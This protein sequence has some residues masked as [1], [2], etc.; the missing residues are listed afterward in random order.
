M[1][2]IN[3]VILITCAALGYIAIL[4]HLTVS[5]LERRH[6]R[7]WVVAQIEKA[8][9]CEASIDGPLRL[10]L[11]VG[12][13]ISLTGLH[14]QFLQPH[15]HMRSVALGHLG[16]NLALW[17]LL[18]DRRVAIDHLGVHDLILNLQT[19]AADTPAR[20]RPS[21]AELALPVI[22]RLDIRNVQVLADA[23]ARGFDTLIL[24]HL[25]VKDPNDQDLE[26]AGRGKIDVYPFRL[27]GRMG[28]VARL[29][30]S[31]EPYNFD[32]QLRLSDIDIRVGGLIENPLK[33]VGLDIVIKAQCDDL[34]EVMRPFNPEFPD[35]GRLKLVA[36][37]E[38]HWQALSANQ[39][40]IQLEQ[41]D[42]V[43][44]TA[45]GRIDEL[46]SGLGTDLKLKGQIRDR[47]LIELILPGVLQIS[48]EID[49]V[50]RLVESQKRFELVAEQGFLRDDDGAVFEV[51]GKIRF[52]SLAER[53]RFVGLD[54]TSNLTSPTTTA[55]NPLM[56]NI[57]P[58]L[59]PVTASGRV[60]GTRDG[61]AIENL[62]AQLGTTGPMTIKGQGRI[63]RIPT[64]PQTTV[65]DFDLA[66]ALQTTQTEAL[67]S[68][69][70]VD[71]PDLGAIGMSTRL[72]GSVERLAFN[73][74]ALKFSQP[75]KLDGKA[76]G[77]FALPTKPAVSVDDID[78]DLNIDASS[79]AALVSWFAPEFPELGTVKFQSNLRGSAERLVFD[80]LD[81]QTAHTSGFKGQ[82]GGQFL[83][84]PAADSQ[85]RLDLRLKARATAPV[86]SAFGEYLEAP[87]LPTD[88]GPIVVEGE[89][90]GNEEILDIDQ[91][92]I[93]ISPQGPLPIDGTG[94][95]QG[96]R[97]ADGFS[98]ENQEYHVRMRAREMQPVKAYIAQYYPPLLAWTGFPQ[99][100]P[101]LGEADLRFKDGALFL[102]NA[103]TRA[104][105]TESP[106]W[107]ASATAQLELESGRIEIDLAFETVSI[108]WLA[109]L[110]WDAAGQG[111][112][113]SGET[114][115]VSQAQRLDIETFRLQTMTPD[116]LEAAFKGTLT[117]D[118]ATK[119]IDG[120]LS[121]T[122]PDYRVLAELLGRDIRRISG[123]KIEGALNGAVDDFTFRG[124]LSIGDNALDCRV[125]YQLQAERPRWEIDATGPR[126]HARDIAW[127]PE[128]EVPME[129]AP[130]DAPD[131]LIKRLTQ[132]DLALSIM[133]D[134]VTGQRFEVGPFLMDVLQE[135]GVLRAGV[136]VYG[137]DDTYIV[138]DAHID[139][140]VPV[141]RIGMNM[142]LT[143]INLEKALADLDAHNLFQSG[144]LYFSSALESSGTSIKS[145]LDNLDGEYVLV[146][147]DGAVRRELNLLAADYFDLM[148]NLLSFDPYTQ[149]N[150]VVSRFS[151]SKGRG[152]NR[153]FYLSTPKLVMRGA[154]FVD[155]P[156]NELDLVFFSQPTSRLLRLKDAP[157][158]R[159]YGPINAPEVENIPFTTAESLYGGLFSTAVSLP[160]RA[161]DGLFG[162]FGQTEVSEQGATF[163]CQ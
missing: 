124:P 114:H 67:S 131:P 10:K 52:G 4:T 28:S 39:L 1:R 43:A 6:I 136:S 150:C 34:A 83:L 154:G 108:P 60:V 148:F 24:E 87:F 141:P 146:V 106:W 56:G 99:E 98:I 79:T 90:R 49:M 8:L 48:D 128:K 119:H 151:F 103:I 96:L 59:G 42:K 53:F 36:D 139:A 149:L 40:K 122:M 54:L 17:P 62:T 81:I 69:L 26:I 143:G 70:K 33:G 16:V 31:Q 88:A 147:R 51:N 130:S 117:M 84:Q 138:Y 3:A 50:G 72:N 110:G 86:V 63:G 127:L 125:I 158:V 132:F 15:A 22:R 145:F 120:K 27:D 73:E 13:Q 105:P 163:S 116:P 115:L 161:I 144:L 35:L 41:A 129:V 12:P 142:Q 38:G 126:F 9:D 112:R 55:V 155:F 2:W 29:L 140:S 19:P 111:L 58:E 137:D 109:M 74:L 71:L 57:F 135:N 66:I 45:E 157:P 11:F 118:T 95:I 46:P 21:P 92:A 80:Q 101:I 30:N 123:L 7:P 160:T 37:L 121:A 159:V 85:S 104:G 64:Q 68:W 65:G 20:D 44:L 32:L 14:L 134:H 153:L 162:F 78:L 102:E 25:N 82:V 77:H 133:I 156:Q 89:I 113:L 91:L 75:E 47:Q 107:D 100:G 5:L 18:L 152:T 76:R 61:L 93:Q 23:H 94:R 97:F